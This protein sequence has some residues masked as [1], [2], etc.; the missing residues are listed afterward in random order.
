MII[1][2]WSNVNTKSKLLIRVSVNY[3]RIV[4]I[5]ARAIDYIFRIMYASVA[6]YIH[7]HNMN[8]HT[9]SHICT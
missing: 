5:K 8:K 6:T 1:E 4:E 3:D 9:N 2:D 7:V